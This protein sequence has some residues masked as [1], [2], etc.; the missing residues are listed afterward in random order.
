MQ[1]IETDFNLAKVKNYAVNNHIP[2]FIVSFENPKIS[3]HREK[4]T[5]LKQLAE[6]TGGK[7]FSSFRSNL[8]QI[9][10]EINN[11]IESRYVLSYRSASD[12]D[13]AKQ[14]LDLKVMVRFQNRTGIETGGYFIP[15]K[16]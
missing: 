16:Q 8:A 13:W 6:S 7:Y 1:T 4:K 10:Q 12:S 11:K 15:E 14:F 3:Q 2:L 5:R 9:S